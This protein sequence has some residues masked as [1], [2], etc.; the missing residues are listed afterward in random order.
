MIEP[1]SFSAPEIHVKAWGPPERGEQWIVNNKLY[2]AKILEFAEGKC[3]SLHY[4]EIKHES[5]LIV[6]GE[7]LMRWF[8]LADATELTKTLVPGDVITIPPGN[9][10]QLL[11][12]KNS[13]I[14]EV[15]TTH[16]EEDS[17]RIAKGSSQTT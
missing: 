2:C 13:K 4:H 14:F 16:Q 8:N 7:L 1:I 12:L 15:S 6:E 9:P 11:A 5:W 17:Y 3:M 10:H